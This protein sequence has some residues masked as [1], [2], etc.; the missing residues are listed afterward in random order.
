MPQWYDK[1]LIWFKY[2]YIVADIHCIVINLASVWINDFIK[3]LRNKLKTAYEHVV[4]Y[5]TL[6]N[7]FTSVYAGRQV[8]ISQ[9]I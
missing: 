7:S 9:S 4:S 8:K 6:S 3:C 1:L 2:N 5:Q